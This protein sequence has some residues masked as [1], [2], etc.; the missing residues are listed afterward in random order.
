MNE[1]SWHR[2][3]ALLEDSLPSEFLYDL[4]LYLQTCAHIELSICTLICECEGLVEGERNWLDRFQALQ[5]LP[6]NDL[7]K[8]LSRVVRSASKEVAD[9]VGA[10]V[11][12]MRT[13]KQNRHIAAHGAFFREEPSGHVRVIYAHMEGTKDA[14]VYRFEQARLTRKDSGELIEDADR[15][16]RS[17]FSIRAALEAQRRKA[18][19]NV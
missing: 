14:R 1:K 18:S 16:L 4:G 7:L 12:W 11:N 5:K 10:L 8:E 13:Y 6:Q 9:Q 17:L 19:G 3:K 15:I 2:G